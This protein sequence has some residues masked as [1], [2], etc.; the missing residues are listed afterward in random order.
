MATVAVQTDGTKEEPSSTESTPPTSRA[1]S[2]VDLKELDVK[3]PPKT[4]ASRSKIPVSMYVVAF[5]VV[6]AQYSGGVYSKEVV[7][8]MR[9][10]MVISAQATWNYCEYLRDLM[11]AVATGESKD[12]REIMMATVATLFVAS[13]LY[14]LIYVPLRAGMWTGR[15]ARRHKI[16]RYLGLLF[17]IQYF[18][19]WIEFIS[20][21]DQGGKDSYLSHFIGLN[22]TV[23]NRSVVFPHPRLVTNLCNY[24]RSYS[25]LIRVLLFQGLARTGRS[26]LLLRQG[27]SIPYLYSREHVLYHD[28]LL[29]LMSISRYHSYQHDGASGGKIHHVY[30]HLLALCGRPTVLSPHQL[31]KCWFQ[32]VG[33]FHKKRGL[34]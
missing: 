13:T 19:A 27:S 18:A 26:W 2:S 17:L 9:N 34:L 23:S 3:S 12:P 24:P 21:Y 25:R 31:L 16:H 5:L 14:V 29:G 15:R 33:S 28:Y 11:K 8:S 6:G 32:Y 10:S 20:N 7:T 4:L 30:L 22:G 1:N